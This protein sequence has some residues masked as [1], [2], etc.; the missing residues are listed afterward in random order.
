MIQGPLV[1]LSVT[2]ESFYICAACG[3]SQ[4][5]GANGAGDWMELFGSHLCGARAV[6]LFILKIPRFCE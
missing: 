6:I 3:I 1:R 4:A 5:C 2:A